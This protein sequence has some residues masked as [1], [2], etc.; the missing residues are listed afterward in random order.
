MTTPATTPPST[1]R[2]DG[3]NGLRALFARRA[4]PR[5]GAPFPSAAARESGRP[6]HGAPDVWLAGL[7]LGS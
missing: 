7:R 3:R 2:P 1:P 4:R 5:A 6:D